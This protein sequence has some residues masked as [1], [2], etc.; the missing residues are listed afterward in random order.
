MV[1]KKVA[2]SQASVV[3]SKCHSGWSEA[4][5][6][7]GGLTP[8]MMIF[9]GNTTRNRQPQVQYNAAGKVNLKDVNVAVLFMLNLTIFSKD[10]CNFMN[11]RLL[12]RVTDINRDCTIY[13]S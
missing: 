5:L 12:H 6:P 2:R 10:N 11:F 9:K 8:N 3:C 1:S 7:V 4:F 13:I